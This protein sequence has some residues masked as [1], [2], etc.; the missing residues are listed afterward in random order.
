MI[1]RKGKTKKFNLKCGIIT[2]TVNKP[3]E[4]FVEL[5]KTG[6][7]ISSKSEAIGRLISLLMRNKVSIDKIIDTLNK[8]KCDYTSPSC[9]DAIREMLDN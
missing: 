3:H 8:V 2:I 1:V 7:C 6:N 9:F 5:G 4:I